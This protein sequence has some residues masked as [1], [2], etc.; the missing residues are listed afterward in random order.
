[1]IT[2][3]KM[4]GV[5]TLGRLGL[6]KYFDHFVKWTQAGSYA[7]TPKPVGGFGIEGNEESNDGCLRVKLG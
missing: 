5:S 7:K 6:Q 3:P 4:V 2:S 1:M